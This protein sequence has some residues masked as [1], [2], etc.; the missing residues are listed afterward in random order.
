MIVSPDAK[1]ITDIMLLE[2]WKRPVDNAVRPVYTEIDRVF[3]L[4]NACEH[5]ACEI[6]YWIRGEENTTKCAPQSPCCP[7]CPQWMCSSSCHC[8]EGNPPNGE[9]TIYEPDPNDPSY[10][11][12]KEWNVEM[13]T[14]LQR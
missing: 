9:W 10:T 5:G 12:M 2:A 4:C 7:K 11:I 1:P 6:D 8:G 13:Q 3:L 14:Y